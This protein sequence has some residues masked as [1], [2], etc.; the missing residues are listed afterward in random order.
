MSKISNDPKSALSL[1]KLLDTKKITAQLLISTKIGKSLTK[2]NDQPDPERPT[3]DDP[4]ILSDVAQM[5][6]HLKR[7]W[8]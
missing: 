1:L 5:K 3:A 2:V 8:M 7:K 4:R 6:E